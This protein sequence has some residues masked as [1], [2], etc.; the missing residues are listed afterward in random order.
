MKKF[1]F[2]LKQDDENSLPGKKQP[3]DSKKPWSFKFNF[4]TADSILMGSYVPENHLYPT[5][6]EPSAPP[7]PVKSNEI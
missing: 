4:L 7:L 2:M 5:I 6:P 1:S 3:L